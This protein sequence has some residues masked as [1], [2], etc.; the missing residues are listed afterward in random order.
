MTKTRS[1]SSDATS[2]KRES[3][4]YTAKYLRV[5]QESARQFSLRGYHVA[6]TK[7]IADALGVQQGSLY[8]YITSKE[9]ALQQI[10]LFA[11]E[12][13]VA[14]S[15]EI[16]KS[17]MGTP[18]K[19]REICARHL[20]TLTDRPEFFKVFLAHRQEL[21]DEA[22]HMLGRQ[23]REY[24]GNIEAILRQGVRKG[25]LRRDLDCRLA[26]LGL[27]GMCNAVVTWWKK[28]VNES[29]DDIAQEFSRLLVQGML[30]QPA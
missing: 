16:R 15:S 28:R 23:I 17:R 14:F 8:Y 7:D 18:D 24:E 4:K 22:R 5:L 29:P 6:T 21:G 3:A 20:H 12:G 9:A 27:L 10:C 19:I 26:T 25:E 2:P 11:I 1:A 30:A 13:Y